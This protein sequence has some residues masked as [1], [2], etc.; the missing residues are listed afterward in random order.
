VPARKFAHNNP[1]PKAQPRQPLAILQ[2]LESSVF[3]DRWTSQRTQQAQC[4]RD[5]K[6]AP[7]AERR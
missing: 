5:P 6:E 7:E 3:N 1:K 4:I 2:A